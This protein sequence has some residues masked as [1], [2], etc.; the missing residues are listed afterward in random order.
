MIGRN[1]FAQQVALLLKF[2]DATTDPNVAASLIDKAAD[3]K[4]RLEDVPP[5]ESDLRLRAGDDGT[6]P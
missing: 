1:Y 6:R 2:A 4:E 5:S 3:L